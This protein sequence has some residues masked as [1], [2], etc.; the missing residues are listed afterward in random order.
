MYLKK[1]RFIRRKRRPAKR[2][3]RGRKRVFKGRKMTRKFPPYRRQPNQTLVRDFAIESTLFQ[4]NSS[5]IIFTQAFDCANLLGFN[6]FKDYYKEFKVLGMTSKCQ[7]TSVGNSLA[8][9]QSGHPMS[10]SLITW[11]NIGGLNSNNKLPET[12]EGAAMEPYARKHNIVRGSCRRFV[13]KII[14]HLTYSTDSTTGTTVVRKYTNPW[15]PTDSATANIDRVCL[16]YFV[17]SFRTLD[18]Q[19]PTAAPSLSISSNV[20]IMFRGTKSSPLNK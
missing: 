17:P 11:L 20:R 16:S 9:L 7:L 14:N 3:Y 15:L 5:P 6:D 4:L 2:V 18:L 12:I 19:D 10:E 8:H 13:P 1:K